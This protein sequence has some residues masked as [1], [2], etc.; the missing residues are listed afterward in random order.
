M[1]SIA[2]GQVNAALQEIELLIN[3]KDERRKS[4][5]G[6]MSNYWKQMAQA[7]ALQNRT[8]DAM[9]Y[10]E[11]GLLARLEVGDVPKPGSKDELGDEA[12]Q[13]WAK[14]G[15]TEEGWS[16]WYGRRANEIANQN[17]NK[18]EWE[19][20]QEPLPSFE[21]TDLHGKTWKPP[22]LKGRVVFLNFWASW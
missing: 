8:T 4:Y 20:A 5:A 12:H 19:T 21:L 7:A 15:G 2:L 13:L 3:S 9:A 1:A 18:L 22:D 17:Q 16:A 11:S 6:M 10:Y 14:L